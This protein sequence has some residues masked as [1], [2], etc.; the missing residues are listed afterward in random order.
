[1]YLRPCTTGPAWTISNQ[2]QAGG[3]SLSGKIL[4]RF[5]LFTKHA[6]NGVFKADYE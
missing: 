4:D 3:A 2:Y 1:M 5:F 6:K